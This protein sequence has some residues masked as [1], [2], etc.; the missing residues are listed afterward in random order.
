[1]YFFWESL[2]TKSLSSFSLSRHKARSLFKHSLFERA[3]QGKKAEITLQSF[4]LREKRINKLI[5]AL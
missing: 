5:T 2:S 3:L 1:M 4:H